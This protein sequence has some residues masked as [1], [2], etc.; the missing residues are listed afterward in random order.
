MIFFTIEGVP[1]PKGRARF[2]A[3]FD[4]ETVSRAW[5]VFRAHGV[6]TVLTRPSLLID[7]LRK[8]LTVITYTPEET[9]TAEEAFRLQSL[10]HRPK[11]RLT[12]ALKVDTIFVVPAPTRLDADRSRVWPHVKPDDDNYRKLVLDALNEVFWKDDGQVCGGESY[13]VYG[14]PPRTVVR[15]RPLTTE[16]AESVLR[17]IGEAIP[18][19]RL[20]GG[21][22]G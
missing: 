10:I 8:M 17:S 1:V 20:F 16:D 9:A 7:V 13:K 21:T 15:I 4:R 3:V 12:G 22:N 14:H 6:S 5:D 11:K 18:Q 2:R 19:P